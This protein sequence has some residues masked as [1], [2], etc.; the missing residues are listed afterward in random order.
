MTF[1]RTYI[2]VLFC[3]DSLQFTVAFFQRWLTWIH[4][5]CDQPH[6]R[7]VTH[8]LRT[9]ANAS[10]NKINGRLYWCKINIIKRRLHLVQFRSDNTAK[11]T[12]RNKRII[13]YFLNGIKGE[14]IRR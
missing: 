4:S 13:H 10:D 6:R 1:R 5:E 11:E 3:S 12:L 2:R 8:E 14:R 9:E 7:H